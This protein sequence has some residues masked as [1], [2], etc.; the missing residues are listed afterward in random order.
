MRHLT[1]VVYAIVFAVAL[2]VFAAATAASAPPRASQ[3]TASLASIAPLVEQ[4]I[5]EGQMPGAV[6]LIGHDGTVVYRRAFGYRTRIPRDSPM[7]V[8]TMF[9]LA[10]LTK[11]TAT[12]PAI[13][14]LFQ[15]GKIRLDD[16]VADYWP[17]F[18]ENG[19]QDVTVRELLTHYSGLPPD[20]PLEQPWSG[21]D[22]AMKLIA[23]AHL[24]HPPGVH[25][26]YSDVNFETLGELVRRI[27]GEPLNVYCE[28]HIYK[29]LGMTHTM[30]LPPASLHG[31][32][33]P[34]Q[35]PDQ[36]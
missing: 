31:Q 12:T 26:E 6:V 17:E 24:V 3:P 21:Y 14:Q 22:T 15:E 35:P 30:F 2:T 36:K 10:S 29:P 7:K 11:V 1:S 34:T 23:A 9:D 18:G 5:R 8:D 25:F 20:L 4:A 33:A 28:E 27:S 16:P 13:M 32:I 19:K